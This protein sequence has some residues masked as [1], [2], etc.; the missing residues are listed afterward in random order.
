MVLWTDG[1]LWA[2][3][4]GIAGALTLALTADGVRGPKWAYV[5][6]LVAV[7][8]WAAVA[9]AHCEWVYAFGLYALAGLLGFVVI[10]HVAPALKDPA[11]AVRS[12][13]RRAVLRLPLRARVALERLPAVGVI[14]GLGLGAQWASRAFVESGGALRGSWA[15]TVLGASEWMFYAAVGLLLCIIVLQPVQPTKQKDGGHH[16][17]G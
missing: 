9:G 7:A 6:G 16:V 15:S 3:A 14:L 11:S 5:L 2:K 8:V 12:A 13:V 17:E 10:A 1:P 4:L